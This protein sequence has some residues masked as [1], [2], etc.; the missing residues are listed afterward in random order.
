MCTVSARRA[1]VLLDL[2]EDQELCTREQSPALAPRSLSSNGPTRRRDQLKTLTEPSNHASTQRFAFRPTHPIGRNAVVPVSA[3]NDVAL[4][5][6]AAM[7]TEPGRVHAAGQIAPCTNA[8]VVS[9]LPVW[10][11][12]HACLGSCT[13][14][15][16]ELSSFYG[17]PLY[18]TL[19]I[20]RG[21]GTT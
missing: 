12:C 7:L 21:G 3:P 15:M 8:I 18:N 6:W 13:N 9:K 11:S 20:T 16:N 19:W 5:H 14:K 2:P 17:T 4:E 10:I 1:L